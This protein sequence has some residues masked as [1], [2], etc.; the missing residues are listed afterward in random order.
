MLKL[1]LKQSLAC[2]GLKVEQAGPAE[3]FHFAVVDRQE[4][5]VFFFNIIVV[6][7]LKEL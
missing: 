2:A 5:F 1:S 7:H 6:K 4:T 3:T